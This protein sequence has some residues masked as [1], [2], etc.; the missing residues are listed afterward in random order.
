MKKL[1][2]IT[3]LIVGIFFAAGCAN[4]LLPPPAPEA[5]GQGSVTVHIGNENARTLLPAPAFSRYEL[6][7]SPGSGQAEKDPESLATTSSTITLEEGSWTITAIAY[8]DISGVTGTAGDEYEA[9]RGS[10]TLTITAGQPASVTIDIADGMGTGQG[11]FNYDLSYPDNVEAAALKILALDGTEEASVDL[12]TGGP[13]GSITLDADYYVLRLE[14]E[15]DGNRI[16]KVEVIHIYTNMTTTAEGTEY[17]FTDE[18]FFLDVDNNA[19]AGATAPYSAGGLLFNMAAVPGGISFPTG[20]DDTGTA[21]VRVPYQIGK[22][23]VTWELWDTVR[24]WALSNG[25]TNIV[26]GQKGSNGSG[27]D[28]QPVTEVNWYNAVVWCNALTE[29]WNAETGASLATVYN[30]DGSPIR[31]ANDTAALDSVTPTPNA[32]GFRLPTNHEWELAARWQGET[33]QGNSV[34]MNGYYYTKGDSASGA[35]GPY[36]DAT[37]TGAVAVYEGNSSGTMD[38]NYQKK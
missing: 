25:Y 18:D 6:Q 3:A 23:E 19:S 37:A 4:D 11:V 9:A 36:T 21:L 26:V 10:N 24:T 32:R 20:T 22:T 15:K 29:W 1:L 34:E 27:S 16:V 30:I 38:V 17:T 5:S 2:N 28:Q 14:L 13:S 35:A 8:V 33:D 31:D 7:F 12:K